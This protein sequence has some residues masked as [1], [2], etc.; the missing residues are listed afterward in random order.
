[1]LFNEIIGQQGVKDRLI[2]SVSDGRISHA[3]LFLGPQGSGN[4][5]LAVAYAQFISCKNKQETDS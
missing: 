2:R 1:M 3:Q 5:A 4:L